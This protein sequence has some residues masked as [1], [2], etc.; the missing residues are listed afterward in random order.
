MFVIR[1]F[2]VAHF[3]EAANRS[4]LCGGCFVQTPFMP[5]VRMEFEPVGHP[6]DEKRGEGF[7]NS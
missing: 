5:V 6:F 2:S 1:R 3:D 4:H 7:S